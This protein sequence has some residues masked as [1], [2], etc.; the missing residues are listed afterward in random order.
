[1]QLGLCGIDSDLSCVGVAQLQLVV[2]DA[3][4]SQHIQ[5]VAN[6]NSP[7]AAVL[8]DHCLV[9]LDGLAGG[10]LHGDVGAGVCTVVVE[11]L[12]NGHA[13]DADI[14]ADILGAQSANGGL[15]GNQLDAGSDLI[16]SAAQLRHGVVNSL[17]TG[18]LDHMSQLEAV[19]V[20]I[21]AD[22]DR[23]GS[24]LQVQVLTV[25]Q[26]HNTGNSEDLAF[27]TSQSAGNGAVTCG[28]R[29]T[30]R[31]C[32]G[33]GDV[34]NYKLALADVLG[35]QEAQLGSADG[36]VVGICTQGAVNAVDIEEVNLQL[37]VVVPVSG[38]LGDQS[39]TLL[40]LAIDL[41]FLQ[42]NVGLG[43]VVVE[44]EASTL[45]ADLF[46]IDLHCVCRVVGGLQVAAAGDLAVEVQVL[47]QG[48]LLHLSVVDLILGNRSQFHLDLAAASLAVGHGSGRELQSLTLIVDDGTGNGDGIADLDLA[49]TVALHVEALDPSA[50]DLH[51]NGDVIVLR[52]VLLVDG[53]D[54]AG[55][56]SH[57]GQLLVG[58]Q[59]LGILQ[60]L[61]LIV[62]GLL[63]HTA[64]GDTL[65]Q[66]AAG[67]ELDGAL[68][69]LDQ[70]GNGDHVVD[71][72]VLSLSA[73]QAV[74]EDGVLGVAFH[75]NDD[76]NVVVSGVEGLIDLGNGT[77]QLHGVAQGLAV[78]Q[79]VGS[80]QDLAHIGQSLNGIALLHCI[81]D[82]TGVE[83]DLAFIVLQGA[84]DGDEIAHLQFICA[85]AL[86]AVALDGHILSALNCDGNS[87]VLILGVKMVRR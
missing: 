35:A 50:G 53:E 6:L 73:L 28:S 31:R 19:D 38:R 46:H 84:G 55:Q 59:L 9:Q 87:D 75:L 15:L 66:L 63:C 24:I 37:A 29:G 65:Q 80:L 43:A 68:I 57:V 12:S 4:S 42:L 32:A 51:G 47:T 2:V 56:S 10:I 79:L 30:L 83:L 54:L 77:G 17:G 25:N 22:A 61:V 33:L 34:L 72:N 27:F 11:N 85:L 48:S 62:G 60:D 16:G 40:S 20:L 39:S 7:V 82:A 8:V 44:V 41:H 71:S 26:S 76:G 45:A 18:S 52:G 86:Q 3:H 67:I 36:V 49:D 13:L 23:A 74:A 14:G 81:Q 69:V 64:A 21:K 5:L 58:A 70:T 78:L 1:M